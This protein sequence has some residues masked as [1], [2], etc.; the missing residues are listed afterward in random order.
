[1]RDVLAKSDGVPLFLEEVT[2]MLVGS[3]TMLESVPEN[4]RELLSTRLDQLPAHTLDTTRISAVVGRRVSRELLLALS[5]KPTDAV[6]QDVQSLLASGIMVPESDGYA[7]KHVLLRDTAYDRML[8]ATRAALHGTV[9]QTLLSRFPHLSDT[10]PELVA[11]HFTEAGVADAAFREWGRAGARSLRNGAYLEAVHHF[12]QALTQ[13][14]LLPDSTDADR[15]A[16]AHEELRLRKDLGVSLIATQGYTSQAV[17]DNYEHALRRSSELNDR[18]EDIPIHVLYGLWGTCLVRGDREATDELAKQF[19]RV[20]KSPDPLAR[21]VAHSTLGARAFYRGEFSRA[22]YHCQNAMQI[23]A[24]AHH[25]VLMRD[26]GYEGAIYS[27]SYVACILC[28]TGFPDRALVVVNE[29]L[30][31]SESVGDPYSKAT[32]LCFAACIARE[33]REPQRAMML[34]GELIKLSTEHQFVM[35]LGIAHCLRGWARVA[36]GDSAGGAEEIRYGLQMWEATGAKVP[37]TYL[38]LN[39]I[40]AELA[41]GAVDAGLADVEQGLQ[42]CRRTL[43]CYQ[44]PEYHRLKGELLRLQGN[45]QMAEREMRRALQGA[46]AQGA[47]W[48][49]LHAALSLARLAS[50]GHGLTALAMPL[51]EVCSRLTEGADTPDVLQARALLAGHGRGPVMSVL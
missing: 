32:S 51:A 6:D 3:P 19:E 38:R 45:T 7:F 10:Q 23:Y 14:R 2:R 20:E 16:R 5:A 48:V 30:R 37:G 46:R 9:A 11:H 12:E 47:A 44:E 8:H 49:E 4:L 35:W 21:H 34:A 39:L 24:P 31:L 43:E 27:H 26:Y 50:Q 22:M 25:F 33:R 40:E 29:A 41:G 42:Q 15:T 18:D 1:M 36:D 13:R 17:A 28:F